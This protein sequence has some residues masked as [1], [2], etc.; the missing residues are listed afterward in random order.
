[1]KKLFREKTITRETEDPEKEELA[2]VQVESELP[3]SELK[4]EEKEFESFFS[5]VLKKITA[6]DINPSPK[7]L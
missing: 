7:C 4:Q 5:E 2:E 1:M 3:A 6:K